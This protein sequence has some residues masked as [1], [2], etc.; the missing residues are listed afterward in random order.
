[1]TT[2]GCE[3]KQGKLCKKLTMKKFILILFCITISLFSQAQNAQKD[4]LLQIIKSERT[5]TGTIKALWKFGDIIVDENLDSAY[6]YYNKAHNLALKQNYLKG[7]SDTY[8]SL[9]YYEGYNRNNTEKGLNYAHDYLNW[10]TKNKSNIYVGNA[11]FSH[12]II[13]HAQNKYDSA[14]YYY[15]KAIPLIEQYEP[16]Q[17]GVVYGNLANIYDNLQYP[18]KAFEYFDKAL[19]YYKKDKDTIGMIT[20]HIN[21]GK[22][23][24]WIKDTVGEEKNYRIALDLATKINNKSRI[25]ACYTNLSQVYQAKDMFDSSSFYVQK[26]LELSKNIGTKE[27]RIRLMRVLAKNYFDQKN[28]NKAY[29]IITTLIKDSADAHIPLNLQSNI[30]SIQ[31][32]VLIGLKKYKEATEVIEKYLELNA[33]I[34]TNE[35]DTQMLELDEKLKKSEQT[36]Q[37]LEKENQLVKQRSTITY[38]LTGLGVATVLG[39]CFFY[40]Q[41]LKIEAKKRELLNLQREQ[42]LKATKA[43]L[44]GQLN[45]RIRI[46]KEIHDDLGSS[47]TSISLLSEVLKKKIDTNIYPEINRIS[48]SSSEMVD[49]M[50]EIIWT[51]NI[52]NDNVQSL[53]AYIRKFA[54]N[55]LDDAQLMLSFEAENLP[56]EKEID[57]SVRR[58]IYLCVKEAMNNIVKHAKAHKINVKI[59]SNTEGLMINIKDDGK[60]IDTQHISIL[61]NG[62]KNMQK[63]M[64]DIGGQFLIH[65]NNGTEITLQYPM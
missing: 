14:R 54:T 44:E 19:D 6:F 40:F 45:E 38:L 20:V 39:L 16:K 42:E 37:L 46:A 2:L 7:I 24:V 3:F 13:Y 55:F 12:A 60:G 50:N 9:A 1:M 35:K 27:N 58:N 21:K 11:L 33:I 47:M 41:K 48:F 5:D 17:L 57:G 34:T 22:T 43:K 56:L 62:L 63:R 26:A 10:A 15:D 61:G 25:M 52:G 64:H 65:N 53:V 51:L 8:S 59:D 4:S 36:K 28:Y 29:S 23:C 18:Q 30:L 32:D 49:K 31:Y